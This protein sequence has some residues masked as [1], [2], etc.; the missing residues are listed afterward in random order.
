MGFSSVVGGLPKATLG[1]TFK[2]MASIKAGA[3]PVVYH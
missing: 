1:S 2:A 3:G